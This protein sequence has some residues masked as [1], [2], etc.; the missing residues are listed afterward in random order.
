MKLI[1]SI[2]LILP[3]FSFCNSDPH[4]PSDASLEEAFKRQEDVFNR[5]IEM[6]TVDSRL[7]RIAQDFTTTEERTSWP[8]PE[9]ELGFSKERWD[10]YR[11][12]FRIADLKGGF[13]R[14]PGSNDGYLIVSTAGLATGGSIKGYVY[15]VEALQPLS[16]SLDKVPYDL[17]HESPNRTV[18]KK[19]KKNWY[20]FYE[21]N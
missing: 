5:I 10:Q 12:L 6:Y 7:T 19:I 4:H 2:F 1:L 16:D 21:A 18:Y 9:S 15:S 13:W 17:L 11:Q 8:C 14:R 3:V 20:L